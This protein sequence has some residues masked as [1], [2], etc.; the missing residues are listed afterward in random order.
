[1]CYF[2][3]VII[4]IISTVSILRTLQHGKQTYLS[5]TESVLSNMIRP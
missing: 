1:V 2:T 3:G 5:I 4:N